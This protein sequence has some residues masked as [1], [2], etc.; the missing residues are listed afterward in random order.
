MGGIARLRREAPSGKTGKFTRR[1]PD[2][3]RFTGGAEDTPPI[4]LP[5]VLAAKAPEARK[6]DR[7]NRH[8]YIDISATPRPVGI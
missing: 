5:L 6:N 4:P 8:F 3:E 7:E 2:A 1:L